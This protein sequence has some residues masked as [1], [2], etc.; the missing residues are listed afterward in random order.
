[1]E[2]NRVGM[3]NKT[4]GNKRG[5]NLYQGKMHDAQTPWIDLQHTVTND[6]SGWI[7]SETRETKLNNALDHCTSVSR[8]H[9][10]QTQSCKCHKRILLDCKLSLA[11]AA[12]RQNQTQ[13]PQKLS[14]SKAGIQL[15]IRH[16]AKAFRTWG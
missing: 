13:L 8:I 5:S 1:M 16:V 3:Q 7:A 12:I 14:A 6:A 11:T 2:L 4:F 10:F 15:Q 9:L